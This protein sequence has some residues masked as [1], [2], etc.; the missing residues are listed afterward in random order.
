MTFL[1]FFCIQT[2]LCQ[3]LIGLL[4]GWLQKDFSNHNQIAQIF[5]QT[6]NKTLPKA[7]RVAFF[8]QK[9]CHKL[10]K[11]QFQNLDLTSAF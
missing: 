4:Q 7:K 2:S 3:N 11:I 5:V 1:I 10:V 9:S 8:H 6:N